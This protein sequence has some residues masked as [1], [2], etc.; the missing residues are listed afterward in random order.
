M[1]ERTLTDTVPAFFFIGA[2]QSITAKNRLPHDSRNKY[3]NMIKT[4]LLFFR[5]SG[6]LI[7]IPLLAAGLN[8]WLDGVGFGL[9]FWLLPA[10]YPWLGLYLGAVYPC[11]LPAG[12]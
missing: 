6:I 4:Y 8:G 7:C 11:P 5:K 1:L 9:G 10:E 3:P 12:L 2:N